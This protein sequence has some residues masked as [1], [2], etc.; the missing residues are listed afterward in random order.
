[1]DPSV[2]VSLCMCLVACFCIIF[3]KSLSRLNNIKVSSF[4]FHVCSFNVYISA[5][6]TPLL[7]RHSFPTSSS[8]KPP[9]TEKS[10]LA[11]AK[12]HLITLC[13]WVP[14]GQSDLFLCHHYSVFVFYL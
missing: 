9:F 3:Q 11:L 2:Y 12:S 7:C 4:P 6:V 13:F 1:M 8:Y 10:L 14:C 5:H